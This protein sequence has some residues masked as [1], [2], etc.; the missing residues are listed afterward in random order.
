MEVAELKSEAGSRIDDFRDRMVELSSVLHENPELSYEEY[1]ASN[2]LL[3]ELEAKGFD[4]DSGVAGLDTAFRGVY[5][6]S[7]PE[8]SICFMLEY[9]ALEDLGHACGHN[10]SGVASLSAAIAVKEVLADYG[11]PGKIVAL[12]TPGEELYSGKVTMVEAG[13]FDDIDVAMMVH[14]FDRTILKPR[15][16]AMEG[17]EFVFHGEPS[18]AAGAP[19]E[20]VN[21]LNG[22]IGTF[23]NVNALRQHLKEDVR[24]HGIITDGGSAINIVPERAAARFFVRAGKREYLDEVIKQVK[25]CAEGASVATGAE[26]EISHFESNDDLETNPALAE[27]FGE[28]I[29]RYTGEVN[30][31][32]DEVLGSTDAGNVSKAVPT[33]HPM[34]SITSQDISLHTEE[35]AAAANSPKGVEGMVASAKG[36][37][38]TALDLIWD[39][40]LLSRVR[41]NFRS[42]E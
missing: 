22:V 32:C 40:H 38:L 21:A 26:V 10:L 6:G 13:V 5:E 7:Q 9:D 35:F 16:I 1:R 15:F 24:I 3:S 19:E 29:R 36:M 30:E 23:E 34:V 25:S 4:V 2:L 31:A 18:H 17:L 12:G 14:M 20:G 37:A 41:S 11:V 27:A 39:D 28:N 33:I 8:P 42:G